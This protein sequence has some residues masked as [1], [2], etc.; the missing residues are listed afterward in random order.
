MI[1]QAI[2]PAWKYCQLCTT[3][4]G[5]GVWELSWTHIVE[6]VE[7]GSERVTTSHLGTIVGDFEGIIESVEIDA[8]NDKRHL[9]MVSSLWDEVGDG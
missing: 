7:I 4:A 6:D 8:V 5:R 1:I 3:R 2:S 9:G